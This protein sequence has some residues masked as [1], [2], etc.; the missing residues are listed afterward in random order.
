MANHFNPPPWGDVHD[1]LDALCGMC[2]AS[3]CCE[4][5]RIIPEGYK[6]TKFYSA[7]KISVWKTIKQ[8]KARDPEPPI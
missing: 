8:L 4:S 2:R 1:D 5:D 6:F 3:S 7:P